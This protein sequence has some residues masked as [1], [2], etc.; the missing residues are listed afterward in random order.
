MGQP[1]IYHAIV[2]LSF[3]I[4]ICNL[5][6]TKSSY[7]ATSLYRKVIFTKNWVTRSCRPSDDIM[8]TLLKCFGNV[9]YHNLHNMNYSV[10]VAITIHLL[11]RSSNAFR[12]IPRS[13]LCMEGLWDLW[14][15]GK[16]HTVFFSLY[17]TSFRN[18]HIRPRQKTYILPFATTAFN[19]T[20]N[21]CLLQC[22]CKAR[23]LNTLTYFNY[24]WFI[25]DMFHFRFLPLR[26]VPPVWIE[27]MVCF[28][29]I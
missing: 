5:D 12:I 22:Y 9:V 14:G 29:Y 17:F 15:Y 23:Q 13:L 24:V 26:V 8:V 6:R 20:C 21:S 25:R 19:Y 4:E 16:F 10:L 2:A 3:Q 18:K 28:D 1:S 7:L 27:E 11:Y